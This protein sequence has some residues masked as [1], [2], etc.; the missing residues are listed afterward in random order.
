VTAR[1]GSAL[2]AA[3]GLVVVGMLVA[4]QA[5]ANGGL[6]DRLG[7]G[8]SG[9]AQAALVGFLV[10]LAVA[11]VWVLVLPAQ[12]RAVVAIPAEL[13]RGRL[14]WWHCAAGLGGAFLILTQS[15]S[16][17]RLG[18]AVFTV[19]V[20]AGQ[21][22]GSLAVDQVGLG[23]AGRQPVTLRRMLAS[24]VA[25][26]AVVLAVSGRFGSAGFSSVLLLLCIVAGVAVAG[27]SAL[28]GR[29]GQ[30]VG[31]PVVAAWLN[32]VVGSAGLAV[33]V[34]VL[35]AAGHPLSALPSTW[36]LYTGGPLGLAFVVVVA[37]S[38]RVVGVLLVSLAT[39]AGQVVGAVL[40]DAFAPASGQTL[41]ATTLAGAVVTVLAV[42]MAMDL[43]RKDRS[44][45]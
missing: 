14:P 35:V 16:V 28:N 20:V 32:F 12:R 17:S 19:A 40:L 31:S 15:A 18:V 33:T 45:A 37:A 10:G 6:A 7:G 42:A 4:F 38:V 22:G 30:A 9:G 39:V 3:S 2:V 24:I 34:A 25:V 11:T 26:G 41:R 29:I 5:R 8:F 23:P 1:S 21:T 44:P 36:W 43:R 13:A 27:Q